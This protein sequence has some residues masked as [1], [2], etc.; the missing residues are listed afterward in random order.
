MKLISSELSLGYL[1]LNATVADTLSKRTNITKLKID[2]IPHEETVNQLFDR[3]P[4]LKTLQTLSL[5]LE[6]A[7]PVLNTVFRNTPALTSL[8]ISTM[9]LTDEMLDLLA[10][11]CSL[12]E[13][14]LSHC[15]L[16]DEQVQRFFLSTTLRKLVLKNN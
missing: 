4:I 14:D 2:Y 1:I 11:H 5:G 10:S 3:T 13:L 15:N 16:S 12:T 7:F 6:D 8:D 9:N